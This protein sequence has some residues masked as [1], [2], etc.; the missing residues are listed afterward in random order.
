MA[1]E[2]KSKIR[3]DER[4]IQLHSD[5]K[6]YM[7]YSQR[8]EDDGIERNQKYARAIAIAIALSHCKM[9]SDMEKGLNNNNNIVV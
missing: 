2:M 1:D 5:S 7:Y 3:E 8:T 9:Q 6:L 4:K